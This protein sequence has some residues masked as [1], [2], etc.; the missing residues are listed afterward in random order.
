MCTWDNVCAYN[1]SM[2]YMSM[3]SLQRGVAPSGADSAVCGPGY[4]ALDSSSDMK[5]VRVLQG[6]SKKR[7]QFEELVIMC[8]GSGITA[9]P[10]N[11]AESAGTGNVPVRARDAQGNVIATKGF[12]KTE[13]TFLDTVRI[14]DGSQADV[15]VV[16]NAV[17][18]NVTGPL[19]CLGQLFQHGWEIKKDGDGSHL[20]VHSGK[21]VDVPFEYKGKSLAVRASVRRVETADVRALRANP[22]G[23]LEE[24]TYGWNLWYGISAQHVDPSMAFDVQKW[25]SPKVW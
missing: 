22:P 21:G 5:H 19:L 7:T 3:S 15:V 1:G 4:S 2:S 9:I 16:D 6:S 25:R 24:Y 11:Y 17:V 23:M 12:R 14:G 13:F 10:L 18:A 8:G 20:H